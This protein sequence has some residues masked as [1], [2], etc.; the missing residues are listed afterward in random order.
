MNIYM[1]RDSKR[2]QRERKKTVCCSEGKL[3]INGFELRLSFVAAN[4]VWNYQ[5]TCAQLKWI[6]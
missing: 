1:E 5:V 4:S 3:S 6:M 2:E